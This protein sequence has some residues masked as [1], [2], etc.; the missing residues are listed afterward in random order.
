MKK[1]Q[2]M[3]QF[4][5]PALQTDRDKWIDKQE[6]NQIPGALRLAGCTT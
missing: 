4:G 2:K 1:S 6:Q 5:D 3:C